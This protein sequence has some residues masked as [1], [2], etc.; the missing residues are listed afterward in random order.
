MINKIDYY[1]RLQKNNCTA[2]I[3]IAFTSEKKWPFSRKIIFIKSKYISVYIAYNI[4][5]L[6]FPLYDGFEKVQKPCSSHTQGSGTSIIKFEEH[7]LKACIWE[8]R[9]DELI[10]FRAK[11]TSETNWSQLYCLDKIGRSSSGRS[12]HKR[13]HGHSKWFF[14]WNLS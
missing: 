3:S 13:E 2:L 12:L 11:T 14:P 1:N 9:K 6:E 10:D 8:E 7:R 5:S 4:R